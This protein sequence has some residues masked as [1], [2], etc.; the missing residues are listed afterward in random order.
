MYFV[1]DYFCDI[2]F[3]QSDNMKYE[4]IDILCDCLE[5]NKNV[6]DKIFCF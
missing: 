2:K 4:V 5:G 3:F 1:N 6:F